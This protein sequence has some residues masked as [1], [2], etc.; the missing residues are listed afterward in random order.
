MPQAKASLAEALKKVPLFNDL[1][2]E[3]REF[4]AERALRHHF[5]AGDLIFSEGQQCTGL[6]LIETGRVRIFG[7][8]TSGREQ[9]LAI[10]GP[11]S[12]VGELAVLDGGNY[13]ASAEASTDA[14]LLLIRR[15]DLQA[16]CLRHPKVGV[17]VL[18]VVASRVR[19]M[20]SIVEQLSFSTVRQRLAA[21]L[22]RLAAEEGK[23]TA[24]G[25]EFRLKSTNRDLAAQIGT[26]PE[27][28]SRNLGSLQASGLIKIRGKTV[29]IS[30]PK[31]V[32][33]E[34]ERVH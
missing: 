15:E 23:L 34:V 4:L 8:S 6:Y 29:I 3:E 24:H 10:Q 25:V 12:P 21:L 11:G 9:M 17:K 16:L 30:D 27:L 20:I 7:S 22:L 14:D 19:P 5:E 33:A 26:V 32:Q 1:S 31:A 2:E 18:E 28:V 13:P